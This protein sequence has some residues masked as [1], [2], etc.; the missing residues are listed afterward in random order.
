MPW[1]SQFGKN[2]NLEIL[3]VIYNSLF[4]S[5][6]LGD[7][8]YNWVVWTMQIEL[9]GSF[10]IFFSA[11]IIHNL[12]ARAFFYILFSLVFCMNY[13]T[14]I[15]FGYAAFMLGAAIYYIPVLKNKFFAAV[16]LLIGLY[17]SGYHHKQT[18]YSALSQLEIEILNKNGIQGSFLY[19]MISGALIVMV[20]IKS[21]I[22]TFIT[23]NRLSIW[24]GKLSFSAY[25]LQMPVFYII[26]PTMFA[27]LS[28][29]GFSYTIAAFLTSIFCLFFLYFISIFFPKYIDSKST[30][31]SKN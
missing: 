8:S 17:L 6:I 14:K 24:L 20:C 3:P 18:F 2:V 5:V 10:L 19:L 29:N 31:L 4:S 25:L 1:I 13:P 11:P 15:G 21:N 9:F 12:K 26:T 7:A 23:S 22:I 28:T 27:Y 16:I 30:F